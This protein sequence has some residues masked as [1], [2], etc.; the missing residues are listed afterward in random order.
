M[1]MFPSGCKDNQN[2]ENIKY[3]QQLHNTYMLQKTSDP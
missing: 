2:A 1:G 3:P